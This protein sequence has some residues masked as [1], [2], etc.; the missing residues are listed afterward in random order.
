[1]DSF[2]EP[3]A[4]KFQK[5]FTNFL[6]G[7]KKAGEK[8]P[9]VA[10]T[11]DYYN[12]NHENMGMALIFNQK[13]FS[14]HENMLKREGNDEDVNELKRI[15][16]LLGFD[17][18]SYTDSTIS[19]V[20]NVL[21]KVCKADHSDN[22][23]LLIAMMSHGERGG[24]I[25]A[26]DGKMR[27]DE[28]WKTFTE[29]CPSLAGKPKIFFIQAYCGSLPNID[30]EIEVNSLN[31]GETC[32]A[33][34]SSDYLELKKFVIP[35]VSDVIVYFSSSGESHSDGSWFVKAICATLN[36][37]YESQN[38]TDFMNVLT[39]I[40]RFIS[41]IRQTN[42]DN[43]HEACKQMPIIQSMLTKIILFNKEK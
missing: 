15:L 14:A 37:C 33:S 11:D 6:S 43:S 29:K 32:L 22:N 9:S 40:N 35:L 24:W 42:G 16:E 10:C 3:D 31:G 4:F 41:H 19:E 27:V 20:V 34:R 2:D 38:E 36:E 25:F 12:M 18:H 39:R 17:V 26:K 5:M 7:T 23:C 13:D 8:Y 28:L 30:A 1:M 21:D